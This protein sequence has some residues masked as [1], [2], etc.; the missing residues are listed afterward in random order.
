MLDRP[1]F[2]SPLEDGLEK[3]FSWI[4][5]NLTAQVSLVNHLPL[6]GRQEFAFL[7][8]LH[9]V[10]D[11]NTAELEGTQT[12]EETAQMDH[13]VTCNLLRAVHFL[14]DQGP[15]EF[16]PELAHKVHRYVCSGLIPNA[17]EY[18]TRPAKPSG[19][20]FYY[21]APEDVCQQTVTFFNSCRDLS[22]CMEFLTP[23]SHVAA[24]FQTSRGWYIPQL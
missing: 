13:P 1:Y 20:N 4:E 6:D 8:R 18:R 23:V 12:L 3:K 19:F 10:A 22:I 24:D 17:G 9:F 7:S 21:T 11:V 5:E 2:H 16:S 15:H 14:F